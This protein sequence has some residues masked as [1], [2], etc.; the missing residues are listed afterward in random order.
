MTWA[1]FY[2]I[3]FIVGFA[4]TMISM[5]LALAHVHL[6]FDFFGDG[7]VPEL[8]AEAPSHAHGPHLS[9]FNFSTT[10]AFLGWFGGT[11][12]LLTQQG[13]VSAWLGVLLAAK[14]G[15]IGAALVFWVMARF[16]VKYDHTM[17]EAEFALVGTVGTV[18]EAIREHGG[19]GEMVYS[20]GGTRKSVTARADGDAPIGL[21]EEVAV[22]RYENGVAYV[23]RFAELAEEI[24]S[25]K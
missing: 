7:E 17:D 19:Y 24:Q 9:V 8:N 20:Q 1:D 13:A 21:G 23:R 2:L 12:Y 11:G 16:M 22:T 5:F 15:F 25:S 4:M 18:T 3:C 6:D 14:A 10:M